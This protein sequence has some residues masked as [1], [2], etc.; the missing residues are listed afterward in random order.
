MRAGSSSMRT[1]VAS[2]S[3]AIARPRPS[4][5]TMATW[6]QSSAAKEMVISN[7][8][9]VTTR[10]VRAKPSATLSSLSWAVRPRCSQYSRIRDNRN[11]S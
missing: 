7:A 6:E 9:A 5:L 8:A 4:I 11:T 2:T 10:P 1:T 3:T